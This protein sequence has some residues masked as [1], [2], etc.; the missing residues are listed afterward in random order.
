MG[1]ASS[2]STG[3]DALRHI[4]FRQHW[5]A[6]R[7]ML[8]AYPPGTDALVDQIRASGFLTRFVALYLLLPL[9]F[10]REQGWYVRGPQGEM[11]AMVYLRRHVRQGIRVMH[12]DDINVDADYR[13]RGLAQRLMRLAEELA[14]QEQ[15]PFL[16][17][18]VTVA[19]TPAVTLYRS[20]GYL[21]QHHQFVTFNPATALRPP[22]S[23]DFT[24]SPLGRR[25]AWR[26]HQ[27]FY[28]LE[29]QASDPAVGDMLVAYYPLGAGVGVPRSG[30]LRYAL[31]LQGQQV[32][33]ADTFLQ[34]AQWNMRLYLAP[35]C[36]GRESE[37][38][39]IHL[40]THAL[41]KRVG[42]NLGSSIALYVPSSAHFDAMCTSTNSIA[43][44]LDFTIQS[45]KRMI[46]VKPL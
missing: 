20:L 35:S 3:G 32:G 31:W 14:L 7:R 12:I 18:A 30:T 15:R 22:G 40:L 24:L 6:V 44:E 13:R 17:L 26:A 43:S 29:M 4:R 46:M 2:S 25:A 28:R 23:T 33:Y 21:E 5:R 34:G 1:H 45:Y 37:R 42:K 41:T 27:Q 8:V 19:N 11:A 38:Q 10:A 9:D 36:W 39:A 16:K